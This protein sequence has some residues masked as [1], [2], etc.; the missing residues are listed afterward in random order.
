MI[1]LVR[2]LV[3]GFKCV[4]VVCIGVVCLLIVSFGIVRCL[5]WDIVWCYFVVMMFDRNY[6]LLLLLL[7]LRD[8]K[9]F[10]LEVCEMCFN[11]LDYC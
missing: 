7:S 1:R 5:D 8:G 9:Y 10:F 6:V 4:V 2:L 11:Y 3:V